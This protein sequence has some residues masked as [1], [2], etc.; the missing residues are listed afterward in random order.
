MPLRLMPDVEALTVAYLKAAASV[1]AIVG[2]RVA[3]ERPVTL[4]AVTVLLV[5][6]TEKMREHLDEH[7]LQ[8]DAWATDKATASLLARTT[9][10]V[11][12]RAPEVPHAR[13]VVSHV[14]TVTPPRWFPDT[15][16]NQRPRYITEMAVTIHPNPL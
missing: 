16:D 6:G 9:R 14:R 7:V 4:P 3:S 5:T 10:A 1:Q 13:G 12:L 2:S 11:L 15:A 8:I